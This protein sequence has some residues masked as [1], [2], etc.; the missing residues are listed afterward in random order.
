MNHRSLVAVIA[1]TV[2]SLVVGCGGN[3]PGVTGDGGLDAGDDT[4]IDR[5]TVDKPPPTADGG[6]DE[7]RDGVTPTAAFQSGPCPVT[8]ARGAPITCGTVTVPENYATGGPRTVRLAVAIAKSQAPASA[9]GTPLV[10][11]AGGPGGSSISDGLATG[12]LAEV[13]A[14]IAGDRDFVLVDQRGTGFSIPLLSCPGMTSPVAM[15]GGMM[16]PGTLSPA[17]RAQLIDCHD[18][19]LRRGFD[20]DQYDTAS[21]AD[22]LDMI[23]QA[24]GYPQWDLL[25]GSYGTRLALEVM[26]RH[27]DG[28]RAV[29]LDSVMPPQVDVVAEN[30]TGIYRALDLMFKR[31]EAGQC[32]PDKLT[33]RTTFDQALAGVADMPIALAMAGTSFTAEMFV[34]LVGQ[35]LYQ[36]DTESY[37]A[38]ITT[39]VHDRD[40]VSLSNFAGL[41]GG[42]GGI[43][44]GLHLSV[45]CREYV[46]FTTHEKIQAALEKI[47]EGLRPYLSME[48][49][50]DMCSIWGVSPAPDA[51]RAAVSSPLPSLV[52]AGTIDPA[53]PPTWSMLVSTSLSGSF[54]FEFPKIG[55]GVFVEPCGA[56]LITTFLPQPTTRPTDPACLGD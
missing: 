32:G 48:K 19:F 51:V 27:P 38:S 7:N 41:F 46:P 4:A 37:I 56:Q 9:G 1:L 17:D 29:I 25:G 39:M 42:E 28:L 30:P 15:P 20:L 53:T 22:D 44:T 47:P 33:L 54:Y 3:A 40:S 23:R 13:F 11:L 31:C 21:S 45:M 5:T 8:L 18:G 43:S 16:M 10:Y 36:R 50:F 12:D 26:R 2:G 52:L 34:S 14:A 6:T 24:L 55:H 49:Y 35:L